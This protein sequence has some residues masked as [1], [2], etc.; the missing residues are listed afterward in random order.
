[1]QHDS[2]AIRLQKT[3]HD[4][5]ERLITLISDIPIEFM[6]R[7]GGGVVLIAPEYYWG[8]PSAETQ[9]I[10]IKLKRQYERW[11]ELI[12]LLFTNAPQDIL[13]QLEKSDDLFRKWLELEN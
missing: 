13:H 7:S 3:L 12:H 11:A 6:N 1:M 10:Q 8:K 4:M 5:T 9:N 2:I